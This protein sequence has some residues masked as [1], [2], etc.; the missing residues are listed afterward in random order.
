[1]LHLT[2]KA[3]QYRRVMGRDN[4]S[5]CEFEGFNNKKHVSEIF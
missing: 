1:M 5:I 2:A 4:I 3:D